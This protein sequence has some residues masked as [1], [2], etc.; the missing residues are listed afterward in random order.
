[1]EKIS[2]IA[3][4]QLDFIPPHFSLVLIPY[5]DQIKDFPYLNYREKLFRA[6]RSLGSTGAKDIILFGENL[7]DNKFAV[8]IAGGNWRSFFQDELREREKSKLPPFRQAVLLV[9]KS[10]SLERNRQVFAK[11]TLSFKNKFE[12]T[13]IDDEVEKVVRSKYLTFIEYKDFDEFAK[14]ASQGSFPEIHFEVDPVEFS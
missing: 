13:P 11:A 3:I 9:V 4:N 7:K 1:M 12:F 5:F 2:I 8:Q 14:I 6:I 10:K